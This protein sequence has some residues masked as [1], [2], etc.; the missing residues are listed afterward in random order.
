MSGSQDPKSTTICLEEIT[1]IHQNP[2]WPTLFNTKSLKW[3]YLTNY[4]RYRLNFGVKSHV[5]NVKEFIEDI[6]R[7]LCLI[8]FMK[9]FMLTY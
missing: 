7:M 5:Y 2:R 1:Q 9:M 8:I 3:L 6:L 4:W